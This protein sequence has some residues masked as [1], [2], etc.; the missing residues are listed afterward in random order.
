MVT[1]RGSFD[2][3]SLTVT[4]KETGSGPGHHTTYYADYLSRASQTRPLVIWHHKVA[5]YMCGENPKYHAHDSPLGPPKGMAY[6]KN[7]SM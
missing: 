1:R 5:R 3:A 7:A 6:Y 4:S 2:V